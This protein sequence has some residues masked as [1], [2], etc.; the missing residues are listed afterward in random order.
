M[1]IYHIICKSCSYETKLPLGSSDLD[2][3]LSDIN[4]DYA[5]Y[6]LF[7]C[8]KE[9]KF[10]HVDSHDKE[11]EGRCPSDC[12]DLMEIEEIPPIKC[13]RCNKDGLVSEKNGPLE[14]RYAV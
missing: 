5:E 3:I 1:E 14:G 10:V 11:F 9:A 4:L 6:R 12:S 13:P 7:M 2:Q 8:E